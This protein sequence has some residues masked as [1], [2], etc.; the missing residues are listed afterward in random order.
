MV[1]APAVPKVPKILQ[2]RG[3][4]AEAPEGGARD[5]RGRRR[6]GPGGPAKAD[7][8]GYLQDLRPAP[9]R[10]PQQ[11]SEAPDALPRHRGVPVR[12]VLRREARGAAG[13][14]RSM[15]WTEGQGG[16]RQ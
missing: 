10:G 3:R 12:L 7:A 5:G 13:G 8:H 9:P 6:G 4:P 14:D 11:H 15:A 16:K 1:D 2:L